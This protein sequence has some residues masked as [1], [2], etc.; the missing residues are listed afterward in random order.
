PAP[1]KGM[2]VNTAGKVMAS[3]FWDADGILM[4]VYLPKGQTING[5][6]YANLLDNFHQCIQQKRPGLA[7]KKNIFHQYNARVHTCVKAMAKINE[8]KYDLLSHPPYS[9]DIAPSDF[10]LFPKLKSF[11]GGQKF[12]TNDE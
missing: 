7:K 4:I 8:L 10:H 9:P 2:A 6:Y 3:V 5:E 1:K 12:A 11:L